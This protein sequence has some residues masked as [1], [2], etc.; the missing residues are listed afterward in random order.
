GWILVGGSFSGAGSVASKSSTS[1]R[2]RGRN[3]G[4][5][6]SSAKAPA[7]QPSRQATASRGFMEGWS[8]RETAR[9]GRDGS[10]DPADLLIPNRQQLDCSVVDFKRPPKTSPG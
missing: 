6:G 5:A 7:T 9:F 3:G 1:G 8:S 2:N 4:S 10:R